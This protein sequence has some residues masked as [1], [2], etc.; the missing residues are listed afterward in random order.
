MY[1]R[2]KVSVIIPVYNNEKTIIKAV[3]SVI[4]QTLKQLQIIIIDDG[5]IDKTP[6]LLQ[7]LKMLDNRIEIYTHPYNKGLGEA[8]N[9]GMRYAKGEFI[10]FLDSDDYLHLNYL[11]S[12]YEKASSEDLDILQS[13]HIK[14]ENNKKRVLPK[15]FPPF[16]HPITGFN[17]YINANFIE[18]TAWGKLWKTSFLKN[19]HL[20]FSTGYYEDLTFT[21]P[22]FT[23]AK[24]V[25][26]IIF[27]G[28]HYMV[29]SQSITGQP[30]TS[31]HIRDYQKALDGLQALFLQNELTNKKSS[32]PAIFG[33]YLVQL[34]MMSQQ[35]ND[36]NLN[37]SVRE[38]IQK[39]IKKYGSFIRNTKKL[40]WYKRQIIGRFPCKYAQLKRMKNFK[41]FSS[42]VRKKTGIT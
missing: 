29:H 25:N 34:C 32:F 28:Y 3:N 12:M 24:K 11:E 2:P 42:F 19:N 35:V 30:T 20:Q 9:T 10:S 38:F 39:M 5:S 23:F 4:K 26:N 31:K 8:R 40:S 33:L 41:N 18:P 22:A 21:F 15:N 13:Q 14:H 7:Q 36:P 27:P 16:A 37:Q 1:H 17:Y 6:V